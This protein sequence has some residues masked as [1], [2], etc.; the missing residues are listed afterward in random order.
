MPGSAG[1]GFPH[2]NVG[3]K[4]EIRWKKYW[5]TYMN[6]SENMVKYMGQW[7]FTFGKSKSLPNLAVLY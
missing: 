6:M 3:W 4:V 7:S 5:E 1:T 2:K